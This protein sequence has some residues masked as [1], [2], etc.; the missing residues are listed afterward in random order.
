MRKVEINLSVA[1]APGRIISAFT[2]PDMLQDWWKVERTHIEL[3]E[4]GLYLLTWDISEHGFRYVSCGTLRRYQPG[5]LLEIGHLTYLHPEKP[6][7]G[8]MNLIVKARP[9]GTGS[10][11]YLCQGGY[12]PAGRNEHWDWYY[13]AVKT[14]WPVVMQTFKAYLEHGSIKNI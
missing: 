5:R 3:R 7:L 2:D 13:E 8:G 12:P 1:A 11:V 6:I 14:A 10:K 9:E 4:G